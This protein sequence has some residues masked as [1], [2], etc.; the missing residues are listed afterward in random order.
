MKLRTIIITALAILLL[1]Y[2]VYNKISTSQSEASKN[3]APSAEAMKKMSSQVNAYIVSPEMLDN[4]IVSSG[5]VSANNEEQLFSEISGKITNIYFKEGGKVKKGELLV[6]INDADLQ[7]QLSKAK[8]ALKIDKETAERNKKLFEKQGISQQE[9]DQ[10]VSIVDQAKADI[11]LLDA[12]IAKTEIRS[13]YNGIIGLKSVSE[14]SYIT[15]AVKIA[16]IQ[17]IEPVKID[18]SVPEKYMN[19]VRVGDPVMFTIQGSKDIFHAK[20]FA[21]EP[22]IDLATRSLLVR[23]I[24]PNQDEKV[25]PGSFANVE[26]T[27]KQ[28]NNA[29]LIP[30]Q[31]VIPVLKGQQV[32]ISKN[33]KGM[34]VPI[35]TGLRN[36]T[37]IEITSGLHPGDTVITTGIMMLKPGSNL[38]IKS[39][40]K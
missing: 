32:Y 6:K 25:L 22:K 26:L 27:L 17:E 35:E 28:I 31:A 21:I 24:C 15:P 8:A 23:A 40:K 19:V 5:T 34:I 1:G 7:A 2:L 38:K 9:Y 4:K 33:G 39:I 16:A 10:S 13:N 11:A 3:A 20:I 12:Q 36:D 30:T 14:G 18:F 37:T 29:I